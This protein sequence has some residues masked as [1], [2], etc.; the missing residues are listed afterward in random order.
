MYLITV[1]NTENMNLIFKQNPV[2][3]LAGAYAWP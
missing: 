3:T 1:S 2:F